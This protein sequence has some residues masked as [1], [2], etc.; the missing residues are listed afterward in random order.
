[1]VRHHTPIAI[2]P[3]IS[4]SYPSVHCFIFDAVGACIP[5]PPAP[6]EALV[7]GVKAVAQMHG[8]AAS[9]S[10]P[11]RSS[12]IGE[13]RKARAAAAAAAS[14]EESNRRSGT[15]RVGE[16]IKHGKSGKWVGLTNN[17]E[18]IRYLNMRKRLDRC[19]LVCL[20]YANNHLLLSWLWKI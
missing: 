20:Y 4:F 9:A 8:E 5:R 17:K 19:R 13:G 16:E 1:M 12:S 3:A 18:N 10:C 6:W 14:L 7:Q 11:R 15:A 2:T